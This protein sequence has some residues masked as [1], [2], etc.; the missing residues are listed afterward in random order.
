MGWAC[1]IVDF[2][3]GW[4]GR[5]IPTPCS[6]PTSYNTELHACLEGRLG[7]EDAVVGNDPAEH[8]V[9]AREP[10]HH[11]GAVQGL[12]LLWVV[13]GFIFW[14]CRFGLWEVVSVFVGL[15]VDRES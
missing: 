11:R 5:S 15:G 4:I 10:G 2:W 6:H 14:G 9:D 13:V 8:A 3:V 1:C 7:E 12:E